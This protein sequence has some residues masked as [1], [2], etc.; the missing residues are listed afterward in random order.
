L[1]CIEAVIASGQYSLTS[2]G[3]SFRVAP[4]QAY[5]LAKSKLFWS[6]HKLGPHRQVGDRWRAIG[7]QHG[8]AMLQGDAMRALNLKKILWIVNN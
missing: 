2:P 6:Q 4:W 8:D 5:A 1:I 7:R 3:Y